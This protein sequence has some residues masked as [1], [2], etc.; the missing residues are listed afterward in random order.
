MALAMAKV[1]RPWWKASQVAIAY[2]T[3]FHANR[4]QEELDAL[5]KVI[6]ASPASEQAY[7]RGKR[8]VYERILGI[9]R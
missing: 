8:E 6:A 1:L 7:L 9:V 3:L 2:K 4:L 5:K